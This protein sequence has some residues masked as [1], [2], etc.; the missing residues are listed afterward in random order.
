M[1]PLA[2]RASQNRNAYG[3][4]PE[5]AN[6]GAMDALGSRHLRWL[7][8]LRDT[9]STARAAKFCAGDCCDSVIECGSWHHR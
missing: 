8:W 2:H 4:R 7:R 9:C 3:S 1:S 6:W 5:G